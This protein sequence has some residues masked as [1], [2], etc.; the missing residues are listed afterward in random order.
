M[1]SASAY[2]VKVNDMKMAT[3]IGLAVEYIED[4]ASAY[5][6]EDI[7]KL[8][9]SNQFK[10]SSKVPLNFGYSPNTYWLCFSV[11]GDTYSESGWVLD[12]PYAPLDYVTF[13]IPDG[14]GDYKELKGG[15]RI[16]RR[17]K[18]LNLAHPAFILGNQLLAYQQYYI[19]VSSSGSINMPLFLWTGAAFT[20][21]LD[22]SKLAIGILFGILFA[23]MLYN[24]FL[25]ISTRDND[26]LICNL[27]ILAYSF[28]QGGYFGIST[29]YLWPDM[30]WWA[31]K[32]LVVFASFTF[33]SI[34]F[35]TNS[36]LKLKENSTF[37]YKAMLGFMVFYIVL[38]IA[39]LFIDYRLASIIIAL[40]AILLLITVFIGGMVVYAR[41]Y[42][43]ARFFLLAWTFFLL[44]M[45][46][47]LLKLL[48]I[49][50]HVFITEHSVQ[51]GFA[52]N[53]VLLSFA[54]ADRVNILRKEKDKAQQEAL[55][56]LEESQLA[57]SKFLADTERL[58]EKRTIELEGANKRLAELASIDVLTG[59]SNRRIFNEAMDKEFQRAKRARNELALIIL[60]ID[61][62]K[63]YNDS[64][65]HLRG[66]DCLRE[67]AGI[68]R[69]TLSRATDTL[70]RYGGEEFAIILCDTNLEGAV[71][72]AESIRQAVED[73][74]IPHNKSDLGYVTVSCGVTSV[75]PMMHDR[76]EDFINNADSALYDAKSA[77]RNCVKYKQV[78]NR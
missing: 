7:I 15:D 34:A 41:G 77:G 68:F 42:K 53:A 22:R 26:F 19:K 49:L 47:L 60:D 5:T 14:K 61:Y 48:G 63:N 44:G 31:N 11:M 46:L 3:N 29:Q 27:L 36:F 66:D 71:K 76:I 8:N 12:L 73:A 59:L 38:S 28:V 10:T 62:F 45:V 54:L 64:Y 57:K 78:I 13:Y 4:S 37:L 24:L 18:Q 72:V 43:P 69:S 32:S 40:V 6:L 35:Y 65:G 21:H 16:D 58:V 30:I 75:I 39:S 50:P 23:L 25:Y 51:L 33:L 17:A 2:P 1:S 70:A 67:L 9:N 55:E 56:H 20:E 52:I 74:Y